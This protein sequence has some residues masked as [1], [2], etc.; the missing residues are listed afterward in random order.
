[1]TTPAQF[2]SYLSAPEGSRIEYKEAKNN[3]HFENLVKYCVALANEGGG[4]ILMG[5]SDTRPRQ[6]VGTLAFAEPGRTEAGLYDRLRHRI[7]IE[8][9]HH[10]GKRVLII[11]VPTRA[12]G[13]AWNFEGVYWMRAG[14]ALVGMSDEQLK[15]IHAETGPDFSAEICT[16]A[17]ISDLDPVAISR[18]R[19][20]WA[21]KVGNV[22]IAALSDLQTLIDSELVVDGRVTYVALVLFG[23]RPALG[24]H[25]AQAEMIFEYRSSEASGPAQD[26]VDFREGFFLFY[27]ALWERINQ[28]NDRQS[29]QD[30]FFRFEIPTFDEIIIREA[31]LN[32]ICHRDYRLGGSIFIRQY[33]RRMEIDSP[34][35]FLPG[36]TPT[37]VLDQ[38]SPRNRRLAEAFSRCGLVE[39]AGQGMNLMFERSIQQGKLKPDLSGSSSHQVRLLIEG[40]VG[41]PA[42]VRFLEKIGQDRLQRFSTHDFL[43]L[44][45]LARDE[46]IPEALQ[47]SLRKLVQ[48]GVVESHGRGRGTKYMLSRSLYAHIGEK[49]VYTRRK[50]LDHETQKELLLKHLRENSDSGSPLSELEQVLPQLSR[51]QVQSLLDELR[52]E[53][54]VHLDGERRWAKWRISKDI[55]PIPGL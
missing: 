14:D 28:R 30:G 35:G 50:G 3:Y 5:L 45:S 24:R 7:P 12:P 55:K 32:A 9:Y 52:E 4:V 36:I 34:G 33:S 13:T 11:H 6:V 40:S 25:L 51:R 37:N 29:Y 53:G 42:F 48:V 1:M 27:D 41:N 20:R 49:G 18:F 23:T 15:A 8:E 19:E 46:E 38:Q 17:L 22:R 21:K 26:R 54:R 44:D 47:P 10:E 39:R 16:D 31:I 2:D 43:V